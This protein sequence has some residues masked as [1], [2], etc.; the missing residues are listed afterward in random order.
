MQKN[1]NWDD[2]RFFLEVAR[3][4]TASAASRRLGVDYTTVA[5]R[6]RSLE[7][8]LGAL[9][10]DKS[11]ST[12]FT[13]TVDGQHL[14]RHAET[15][16][17]AMEAAH[18]EVSGTGS[19][20]SGHVRIGCTEAFG[21]YFVAPQM[22]NFQDHYPNISIDV[23]PVPHFVSLS[24]READIAITL[25]RPARGPYVTSK[26]CDYRL[27]LY[28][29]TDYLAHHPRITSIDDL[30]AHDFIHYVEALAF[31]PQLLYLN[32]IVANARSRLRCTSTLAQYHAALQGRALAI[33]PCFV[34]EQD[35]RLVAVLA[36][37]VRITRH[38]WL[39]YSEDLRRLKRVTEVA[40]HLIE[41]AHRQK[42]W[43]MGELSAF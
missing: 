43:L 39:S 38:F 5:R 26:L 7:E 9:L 30:K 3:A 14:L 25:E 29:T 4:G 31:S 11:R 36:D 15:M 21:T 41:A 27:K 24:R 6:I 23:L 1:L 18:A 12:G 17:A 40:H 2:L 42:H 22:A 37:T 16:E 20:L 10:F 13:L 35:P 28:A 8:S 33:L 32:D 34:A 19:A